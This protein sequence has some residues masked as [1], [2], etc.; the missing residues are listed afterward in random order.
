MSAF[1]KIINVS[2]DDHGAPNDRPLP[3]QGDQ[4]VRDVKLGD[5][6]ISSL[7]VAKISSMSLTFGIGW[8]SVFSLVGVVVGPGG[9][10]AVGVVAE[11][12][13]VEPVLPRG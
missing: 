13:D 12:V 2:M 9:G 1:T 10:A 4:G 7:N 5:S 8:A 6:V 11:L 3:R